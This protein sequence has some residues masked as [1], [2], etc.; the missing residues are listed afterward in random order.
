MQKTKKVSK[1]QLKA[2]NMLFGLF[3]LTF[4]V[5][6]TLLILQNIEYI[7]NIN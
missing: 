2:Q 5:N 3:I 1:G 6:S 4:N 7:L